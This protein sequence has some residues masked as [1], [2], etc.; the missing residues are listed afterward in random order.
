MAPSMVTP[1]K[2]RLHPPDPLTRPSSSKVIEPPRVRRL[3]W[4]CAGSVRRI[5]AV[6]GQAFAG[7]VGE[8]NERRVDRALI[9][10]NKQ[11][12]FDA[13]PDISPR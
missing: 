13:N 7:L 9:R 11:D 1:P 5:D 8:G 4:S 12:A 10:R 3:P 6:E 2:L